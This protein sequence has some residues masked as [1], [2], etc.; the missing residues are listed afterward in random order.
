MESTCNGQDPLP[1]AQV[2]LSVRW[3]YIY[4]YDIYIYR[5]MCVNPVDYRYLKITI[6][7]IYTYRCIMIYPAE[8]PKLADFHN[9]I[10]NDLGH[11][12]TSMSKRWD[13]AQLPA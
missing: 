12:P 6:Y 1:D 13:G 7:H 4:I 10:A 3:F 11:N 8:L 2:C 9:N 5:G